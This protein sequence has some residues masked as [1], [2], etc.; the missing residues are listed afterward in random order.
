MACVS[1]IT[2]QRRRKSR[3]SVFLD[4]EFWVGLDALTA[5]ELHLQ[6]GQTLNEQQQR[7]L[8]E[9]IAKTE[10]VQFCIDRLSAR[11]MSEG[12]LRAKLVERGFPISVAE[13]ALV[14]CHE[15]YLLDDE[16]FARDRIALRR[17]Q[18]QGR[19]RVAT[20]LAD[21]KIAP[22]L[23]EQLLDEAFDPTAEI[24]EAESVLER[25]FPE[26]LD[27]PSARR[28]M[29]FL[30]RRGFGSSAA[31]SVIERHRMSSSELAERFTVAD[32]QALLER[33]YPTLDPHDPGQRRRASQLL[34]RRGYPADTAREILASYE[35]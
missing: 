6:V 3:V 1:D 26:P 5:R 20:A 32:G 29:A 4:G 30:V 27:G 19:R 11:N 21:A 7:Q 9:Q 18:G 35:R 28:A 8:E 33:R 17:A 15:L 22:L 25:R 13:I 16:Q 12:Q 31:Q 24:D 14:R 34:A 23:I 2:P 10:A